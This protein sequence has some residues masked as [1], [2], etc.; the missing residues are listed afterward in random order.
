MIAGDSSNYQ[1]SRLAKRDIAGIWSYL[2]E[3]AGEET[4]DRML[5]ALTD[6]FETLAD[7]PG[8]G[9]PR[10]ELQQGLRSFPQKPY[11]IFYDTDP[12]AGIRIGRVL[13]QRQDLDTVFEL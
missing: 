13:H 8:L 12:D 9:R 11:V 2:A 7:N 4:A 5:T 3:H 6:R 10:D 1:L